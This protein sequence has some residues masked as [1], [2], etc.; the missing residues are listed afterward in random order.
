MNSITNFFKSLLKRNTICPYF[1]KRN[2]RFV[3]PTVFYSVWS[4]TSLD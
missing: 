2:K 1:R 4:R 3:L